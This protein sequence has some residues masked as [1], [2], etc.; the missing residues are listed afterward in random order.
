MGSYNIPGSVVLT[1]NDEDWGHVIVNLRPLDGNSECVPMIFSIRVTV[2][3]ELSPL[4]D[5]DGAK[6]LQIDG[7]ELFSGLQN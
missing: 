7:L 1:A 3:D 2:T 6:V 4:N 5:P